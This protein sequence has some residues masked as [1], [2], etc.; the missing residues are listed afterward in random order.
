[1]GE[2]A[3][4]KKVRSLEKVRSSALETVRG[5]LARKAL[6]L[7][8]SSYFCLLIFDFCLMSLLVLANR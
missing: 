5:A 8:T 4:G 7:T 2:A 3:F 1:M 6:R